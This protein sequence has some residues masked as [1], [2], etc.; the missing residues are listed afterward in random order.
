MSEP[1]SIKFVLQFS[2]FFVQ[3]HLSHINM[4]ILNHYVNTCT[5]TRDFL[6]I[7][8]KIQPIPLGETLNISFAKT[9][10]Y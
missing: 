6:I 1:F 3:Y 7:Y 9:T 5:K 10:P 8:T 4:Q 2:L